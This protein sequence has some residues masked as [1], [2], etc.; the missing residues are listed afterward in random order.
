[1]TPQGGNAIAD[2]FEK[3]TV[4]VLKEQFQEEGKILLTPNEF[5]DTKA[6]QDYYFK[7]F[8]PG[9]SKMAKFLSNIE[10]KEAVIAAE[11][12]GY[13]TFDI[14]AAWDAIRAESLVADLGENIGIKGIL[15]V[16]IILQTDKKEINMASMR[17]TLNGPNPIPKEDKNYVAQNLGNGYYFGQI[18]TDCN[19]VFSKPVL[20]GTY[21]NT[22]KASKERTDDVLIQTSAATIN[23][24][25]NGIEVVSEA[26]T[27]MTFETLYEGISKAAPK[28][29]K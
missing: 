29:K 8:S 20:I 11:A 10:N 13:R 12:D 19:F 1:M 24:N 4:A 7:T 28:Y 2:H 25:I 23:L 15:S 3:Q 9:I 18:Y 22:G 26:L 14:T 27:E 21:D 17:M 6:K 5:L 16:A